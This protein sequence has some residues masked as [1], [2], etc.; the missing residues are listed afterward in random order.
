M[1]LGRVEHVGA[2]SHVRAV[3]ALIVLVGRGD[4]EARGRRAMDVLA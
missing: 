2:D 4:E 1:D 3:L